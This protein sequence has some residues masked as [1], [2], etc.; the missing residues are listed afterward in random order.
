MSYEE[1]EA[2]LRDAYEQITF[3]RDKLIVMDGDIEML[4]LSRLNSSLSLFDNARVL[5]DDGYAALTPPDIAQREGATNADRVYVIED[6]VKK[7]RGSSPAFQAEILW[8]WN[9]VNAS[10][11]ITGGSA[12]SDPY[13][14]SNIFRKFDDKARWV[15]SSSL[16]DYEKFSLSCPPRRNSWRT[17]VWR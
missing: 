10:G 7:L 1:I 14:Y 2:A 12:F 8:L 9:Y 4:E 17:H 5:T 6:E 13:Y 16:R 11:W 3:D 15:A